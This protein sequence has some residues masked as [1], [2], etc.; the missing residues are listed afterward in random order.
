M[1]LEVYN[2]KEVEQNE[3]VILRL[4]RK[5]EC[6]SS[7]CRKKYVS[8]IVVDEKGNLRRHGNLISF[9]DSGRIT[10]YQ[11]VN[12]CFGFELGKQ[13]KLSLT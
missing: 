11:S 9:W 8:L 2:P 4:V 6:D 1:I 13:G 12:P 10:L 3:K 7:G 5:M